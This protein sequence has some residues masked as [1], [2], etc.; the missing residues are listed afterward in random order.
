MT[1]RYNFVKIATFYP[2]FYI[3]FFFLFGFVFSLALT[4]KS[5]G[6]GFILFIPIL[7]LHLLAMADV[8]FLIIYYL[9]DV[10]NNKRVSNDKRFVWG[11]VIFFG[12]IIA[13]PIYWNKYIK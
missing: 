7:I 9:K 2:L 4:S 5:V 6:L 13:C 10:A 3:P 8:I 1:K 11:L 12:N